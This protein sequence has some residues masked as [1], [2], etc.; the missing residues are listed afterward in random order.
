MYIIVLR[1]SQNLIVFA[2][3][4]HIACHCCTLRGW[5]MVGKDEHKLGTGF[6][7]LAKCNY[8]KATGRIIMGSKSDI[9]SQNRNSPYHFSININ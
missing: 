9:Q 4:Y 6:S 7:S 8:C 2:R 1:P 5:Y 3:I